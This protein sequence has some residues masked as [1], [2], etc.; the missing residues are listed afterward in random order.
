M[1]NVLS[2]DQNNFKH[3][4]FFLILAEKDHLLGI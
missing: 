4:P 1:V 2:I 3:S